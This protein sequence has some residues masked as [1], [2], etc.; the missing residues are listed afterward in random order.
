M[1]PTTRRIRLFVAAWLA[2]ACIAVADERASNPSRVKAPKITLLDV[3]RADSGSQPLFSL[4]LEVANSN[5]GSLSYTGYT[6]NSPDPPLKAG[7]VAPLYH[8]ELKRDGKWQ[9]DPRRFCGT[10]LA[11]LELAARSSATFAVTIPADDWQVVKVEIGCLPELSS[12]ERATT[13]VWSAEFSRAEI[14]GAQAAPA[15]DA[16]LP[17]GRWSVEF[18]DGS[19]EACEICADG[20]A[21]VSEPER[22]STGKAKLHDGN[23]VLVFN[24]DRTERWT[25]VGKRFVVEH[26]FPASRLPPVTPVLG[27]AE[28]VRLERVHSQDLL[29]P[30]MRAVAGVWRIEGG[31]IVSPDDP[32]ALLQLPQHPPEEYILTLRVRRISGNNTFAIGIPIGGRQVLVALDAHASTVSGLEHLDGRFVHENEATLHGGLFVPEKAAMVSITVRRD[33]ITCAFDDTTVID[34]RGDPQRLSLA[35]TFAVPDCNAL[36][37]ATLGSSYAVSDVRI[38]PVGPGGRL[39]DSGDR[40]VHKRSGDRP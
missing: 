14:E 27:I 6:P 17:V 24:D 2:S 34:W 18:A 35:E 16:G 36:F 32:V 15:P 30:G 11:D 1:S 38:S 10:G 40:E 21:S 5:D 7:H 20:T 37:L 12:E 9:A 25:A 29:V 4:T 23:L 33:R 39:D 31:E 8:A 3:A 19:V 13:T 28:P 26:W 22:S